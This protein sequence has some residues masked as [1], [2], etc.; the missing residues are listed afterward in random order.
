MGPTVADMLAVPLTADLYVGPRGK[1]IIFHFSG[2]RS[3]SP[4]NVVQV[5]PL[6][7]DP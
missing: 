6:T 2:R 4:I 7:N 1:S 3:R 5:A